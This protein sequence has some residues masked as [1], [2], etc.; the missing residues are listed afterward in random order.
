[1]REAIAGPETPLRL[2]HRIVRRD[3]EIR[4]IEHF[5]QSV[6][7][8]EREIRRPPLLQPRHHRT[9][10]GRGSAAKGES[11][12]GAA[13]RRTHGGIDRDRRAAS[14]RNPGAHP[15]RERAAAGAED[16]GASV[17]FERPRTA[18]HRLR[19]SRRPGPISR[20]G[21][22]AISRLRVREGP[23][24]PISRRSASTPAW[25]CC[26]TPTAKRGG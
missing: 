21:D 18:A 5:C 12:N 20:R 1:M 17:A 23:K 19:N 15:R 13:D 10:A 8:S 24:I 2:V 25:R 22:H 4:W 11:R 9:E 14:Q 6:Y 16:A 7:D 3:G 26:G